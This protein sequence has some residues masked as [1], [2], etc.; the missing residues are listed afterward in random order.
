MPTRKRPATSK[1]KTGVVPA[2]DKI[3]R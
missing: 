3:A 1:K 2:D